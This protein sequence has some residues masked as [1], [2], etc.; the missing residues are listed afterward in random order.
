MS[1]TRILDKIRERFV[2]LPSAEPGSKVV[3]EKRRNT[4]KSHNE[5]R[6]EG[7]FN[8]KAFLD[9]SAEV[10]SQFFE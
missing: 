8:C 1:H 4:R 9:V 5:D 3:P 10:I 2:N 7:D 6:Q